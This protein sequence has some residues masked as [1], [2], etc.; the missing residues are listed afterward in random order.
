M[1]I[2]GSPVTLGQWSAPALPFLIGYLYGSDEGP[3][4]S[5]EPWGPGENQTL[6]VTG[7]DAAYVGSSG[8]VFEAV[9][10]WGGSGTEWPLFAFHLV[11][12]G[13]S[14]YTDQHY[15]CGLV[16][17]YPYQIAAAAGLADPPTAGYSYSLAVS[18][19][20]LPN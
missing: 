15:Q 7:I 6:L 8:D 1:Q 17:P 12:P 16:I 18:G 3:S 19:L 2:E 20:I 10:T 14:G 13:A 5:M 11:A 9:V 4:P